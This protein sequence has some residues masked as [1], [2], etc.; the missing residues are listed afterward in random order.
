[1]QLS[2]FIGRK[3]EI[4]GIREA[5][6]DNRLVTLTG[7]GGAGKT[8]LAVQVAAGMATELPTADHRIAATFTQFSSPAASNISSEGGFT[9]Y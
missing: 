9:R 5:L 1:M 3:A 2:S 7:A 6:A 8:R 4:R